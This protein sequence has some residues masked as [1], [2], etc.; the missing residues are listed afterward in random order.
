MSQMSGPLTASQSPSILL[1]F[2]LQVHMMAK[3]AQTLPRP[4]TAQA[5]SSLTPGPLPL[6][7]KV[8]GCCGQPAQ[9]PEHADGGLEVDFGQFTALAAALRMVG[10]RHFE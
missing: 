1:G 4:S 5:C 7:Q 9:G 6:D 10:P 8:Q 3:V 2:W